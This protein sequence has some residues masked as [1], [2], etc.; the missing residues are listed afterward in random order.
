L[1]EVLQE[2]DEHGVD[3]QDAGE[4]CETEAQDQLVHVPGLTV[5]AQAH[6]GRRRTEARQRESRLF[7]IAEGTPTQ[8]DLQVDI[9]RTV[10]PRDLRGPAAKLERGDILER[11]RPAGARYRKPLECVDVL[12]RPLR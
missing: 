3:A 5:L 11:H 7:D 2:Q 10:E 4:H 9:A 12:S 8:F 6:P 1:E